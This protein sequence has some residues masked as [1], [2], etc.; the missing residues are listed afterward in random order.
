[1]AS[2]VVLTILAKRERDF[3]AGLKVPLLKRLIEIDPSASGR[4]YLSELNSPFAMA[5]RGRLKYVDFAAAKLWFQKL[6]QVCAGRLDFFLTPAL[7]YDTPKRLAVFDFDSTL[8]PH[9]GIDEL[10]KRHGVGSEVS[11]MTKLAMEGGW[12]FAE[13]FTKRMALLQGLPLADAFDIAKKIQPHSG[14]REL[15]GGLRSRKCEIAVASGGFSVFVNTLNEKYGLGINVSLSHELL[16]QKNSKGEE[17]LSGKVPEMIIGP[18]QKKTFLMKK[19]EILGLKPEEVLCVG[20]GA[21]DIPMLNAAGLGI[22]FCAK[23]K[24]QKEAPYSINIP[25]LRAVAYALGFTD[26][27]LE[28]HAR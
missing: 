24:V 26:D 17:V 5:V 10:A 19:A 6:S 13:S 20:D 14:A 9:E 3:D 25:D 27:E 18:E 11:K 21:N 1:M 15:M 22:A 2:E 12:D 23:T 16:T 4:R 7:V 28:V 8:T